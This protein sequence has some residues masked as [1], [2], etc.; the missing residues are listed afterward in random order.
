MAGEDE[1]DYILYGYMYRAHGGFHVFVWLS[2]HRLSANVMGCAQ[3][4]VSHA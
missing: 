4:L 2:Y 1:M 3:G